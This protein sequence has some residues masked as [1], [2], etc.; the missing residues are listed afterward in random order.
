M[1]FGSLSHRYFN[2]DVEFP[3]NVQQEQQVILRRPVQSLDVFEEDIRV[4]GRRCEY[5]RY[6]RLEDPR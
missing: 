3:Q 5:Q 6:S 2:E 1:R 4:Y